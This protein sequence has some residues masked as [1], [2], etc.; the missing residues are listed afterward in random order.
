MDYDRY[1]ATLHWIFKQTQGDAWF[2]PN[3]HAVPPGVCLRTHD[4]SFRVFPYEVAALEPFEAAVAALNPLVAVKVR[5][6]AV[7]AAL[8]EC[9]SDDKADCIYVDANTRIQVMDTMVLLPQA[10]K[11]QNAAFIVRVF[12]SPLFSTLAPLSVMNVSLSSGPTLW[13]PSYPLPAISKTV[14]YASCGEIA[15][16]SLLPSSLLLRHPPRSP[17]IPMSALRKS[18]KNWSIQRAQIPLH[19]DSAARGMGARLPCP[20]QSAKRPT[21]NRPGAIP[22]FMPLCTTAWLLGLPQV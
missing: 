12:T 16:L 17:V 15:P 5:S 8:A 10:D 11:E 7:H 4:G 6:A 19:S 22:R 1:D 9:A 13:T 18:R 2:R 21:K 3:E 20:R 14:S